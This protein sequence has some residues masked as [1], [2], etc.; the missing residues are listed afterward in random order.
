MPRERILTALVLALT[1]VLIAGGLELFVRVA[2]DDGL[3]F[4]LEMWKY[5][6]DVKRVAANPEIGHEH[7]PEARA[8]LMG[9]DVSINRHRLRDREIG[10]ERTPG[11]LRIL[12]LGDSLT[13]GWGVPI[14][15]SFVKRLE[16]IINAAGVKAEVI[17]A[18]VGNYNTSMEIAYYLTEGVRYDPDIVILNYF[19]N[20]AEKTPTY[21]TFWLER[22][23]AAYVY[24]NSRLDVAMRTLGIGSR[25]GWREY[26][27]DLYNPSKHISGW[28]GVE[29]SFARFAQF[30]RQRR[31]T[32]IVV[33]FPELRQLKPYPFGKEESLVRKLA[34]DNELLYL[35]ALPA[36]VDLDP[37]TLWVTPTD[38]HPNAVADDRFA[39]AIFQLLQ[40]RDLLRQRQGA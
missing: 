7:R 18:G 33:N 32:A 35:D 4:D 20:D 10:Y 27:S 40:S 37:R 1:L 9:V 23:S 3:Q 34:E 22:V 30:A 5:A 12:M 11:T 36:V 31:T 19:I 29:R 2:V 6:R 39:R 15:Q 14:Q 26:L 8:T 28:S 24:F 13:M 21:N 25:E 16:A 17:N 38:P